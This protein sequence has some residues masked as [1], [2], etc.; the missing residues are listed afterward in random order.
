[1]DWYDLQQAGDARGAVV[2]FVR[3]YEPTSFIEVV[4]KRFRTASRKRHVRSRS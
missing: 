1:M 3:D 4:E 2:A